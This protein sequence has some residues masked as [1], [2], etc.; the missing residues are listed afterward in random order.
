MDL[1][2]IEKLKELKSLLDEGILTQEEFDKEKAKVMGGSTPPTTPNN[3]SQV[4]PVVNTTP[5]PSATPEPKKEDNGG[6]LRG[7]FKI[8]QYIIG[9]AVVVLIIA[10]ATSQCGGSKNES[11][12]PSSIDLDDSLEITSDNTSDDYTTEEAASGDEDA[13]A[14]ITQR[15]KDAYAKGFKDD[16]SARTLYFSSNLK[17]LWN[18]AEWATEDGGLGPIDYD[19]WA[20]NQDPYHP[21]ISDIQVS[22]VENNND[23]AVVRLNVKDYSDTNPTK[24]IMVK[25]NGEWLI[26]DMCTNAYPSLVSRLDEF[27]NQPERR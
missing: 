1:Q 4:P 12:V 26:D 7:G 19:I 27:I 11:D 17:K 16:Q 10:A 15:V 2:K 5:Q 3:A 14:T 18:D 23:K 9:L 21:S 25:E 13:V 22:I 20:Q 24:L 8:I 6:G